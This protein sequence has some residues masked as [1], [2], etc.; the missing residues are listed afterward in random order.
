MKDPHIESLYKLDDSENGT[1]SS[2]DD[3]EYTFFG[4]KRKR[5]LSSSVHKKPTLKSNK[6]EP[7]ITSSTGVKDNATGS[8][9]SNHERGDH[10]VATTSANSGRKTQ[11]PTQKAK[12]LSKKK[13]REQE[14]EKQQA[15]LEK[16]ALEEWTKE[17]E[18]IKNYKLIV[19]TCDHD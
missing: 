16:K 3:D 10:Q 14:N 17:Y 19:E 7:K 4:H 8:T 15:L 1:D 12:H 5:K 11:K 9:I 18:S 6:I 13:L 2:N